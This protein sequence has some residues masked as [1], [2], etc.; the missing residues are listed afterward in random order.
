[1]AKSESQGL[2]IAVIIFAL[3]TIMLSG[4][5]FYFFKESSDASI[6]AVEAD[7][8]RGQAD[9]A[10]RDIVVAIERLKTIIGVDPQMADDKIEEVYTQDKQVFMNTFPDDKQTYRAAL[11]FLIESL[12]QSKDEVLKER[13]QLVALE[14]RID[15]LEAADIER[16]KIHAAAAAKAAQ[17]LNN[18]KAKFTEQLTAVTGEKNALTGD[19]RKVRDDLAASEQAHVAEVQQIQQEVQSSKNQNELLKAKIDAVEQTTFEVAD[20]TIRAVNQRKGTVWIDLG[21]ADGLMKQVSF[22]VVDSKATSVTNDT[23]KAAIEVVD[24]LGAHLSEAKILEDE[25][26]DPILPGDKIFTPLW[27]PG[28]REH[29]ALAGFMDIDND[30]VDDRQKIID[31]IGINGGVVD[32]EL[33]PT[34]ELVGQMNID[35]RYI[36]VGDEPTDFAE[37]YGKMRG[38]ALDLGVEVLTLDKFLD[39]VGFTGVTRVVPFGRR[40][41]PEDFMNVPREEGSRVRQAPGGATSGAFRKRTPP[42]RG[43]KGSGY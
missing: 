23:R 39:H 9:R 15:E 24:I 1:M 16:N 4:A 17:D 2:Q 41:R 36:V 11:A 7:A 5:T 40:S 14:K 3:L 6:K 22:S 8:A 26:T 27:H 25:L 12:N 13:V 21:H 43:T 42:G 18:E 29:F 19:L 10:L 35:T 31:M 30:E 28:R 37:K 20:G 32:A 34:G 33:T 38:E